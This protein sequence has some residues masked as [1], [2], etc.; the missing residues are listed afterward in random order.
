MVTDLL[1]ERYRLFRLAY[2]ARFMGTPCEVTERMRDTCM[3]TRSIAIEGNQI[4]TLIHK[5]AR[6]ATSGNWM[7]ISL[8]YRN[9]R[10]LGTLTCLSVLT[11]KETR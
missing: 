11:A 10:S 9:M 7:V 4:C 6:D 8:L 2:I 1:E 3:K 5:A